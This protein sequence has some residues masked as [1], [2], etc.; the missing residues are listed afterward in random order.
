[1]YVQGRQEATGAGEQARQADSTP[2]G[3]KQGRC[4]ARGDWQRK[5]S[6]KSPVQALTVQA[7]LPAQAPKGQREDRGAEFDAEGPLYWVIL[8][9]GI[10]NRDHSTQM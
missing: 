8:H 7:E 6:E 2:P 1:M 4:K 5:P 10:A 3:R 9:K